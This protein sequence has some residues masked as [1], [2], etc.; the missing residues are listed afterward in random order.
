[1]SVRAPFLPFF[2][3]RLL[4]DLLT[5]CLSP[6]RKPGGFYLI[7]EPT[8]GVFT[9]NPENPAHRL[10]SKRDDYYQHIAEQSGLRFERSLCTS[11]ESC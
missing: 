2:P 9:R 5:G 1:M 3:L 10:A 8:K 7:T 6:R 4:D 11:L